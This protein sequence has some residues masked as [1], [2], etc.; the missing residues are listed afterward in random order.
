MKEYSFKILAQLYFCFDHDA[1]TEILGGILTKTYTPS[2]FENIPTTSFVPFSIVN[3][4]FHSDDMGF[5][6]RRP[7]KPPSQPVTR[8]DTSLSTLTAKFI[9]LVRGSDGCVDLNDAATT[10]GVQKRRIYD[11]TNVLEGL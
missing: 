6:Y 9:A 7:R 11:I 2:D 1:C 3:Y 8:F 4:S 10:L 5:G